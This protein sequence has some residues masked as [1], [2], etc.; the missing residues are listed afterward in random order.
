MALVVAV[1]LPASA[2][3]A[4]LTL[5]NRNAERMYDLFVDKG[6]QRVKPLGP[7]S[8]EPGSCAATDD[9]APGYYVLHFGLNHGGLCVLG[10]VVSDSTK[11]DI[12]PTE[13]SCVR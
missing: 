7:G 5:C 9:V 12:G 4:R 2:E 11:I 8:I 13:G 6:G 10:I 3:A 1:A